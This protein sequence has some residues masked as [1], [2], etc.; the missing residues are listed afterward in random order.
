MTEAFRSLVVT[1]LP[2]LWRVHPSA[3]HVQ[4]RDRL[5]A[6]AKCQVGCEPDQGCR[7]QIAA[8][9]TTCGC[10][11]RSGRR[12]CYGLDVRES[13]R[14]LRR[15]RRERTGAALTTD[16]VT[17]TGARPFRPAL[18]PVVSVSQAHSG[19]RSLPPLCALRP[20]L[21]ANPN[22]A[23]P[24]SPRVAGSGTGSTRGTSVQSAVW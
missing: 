20:D 1:T 6:N 7:P 18:R 11:P 12:K 3:A 8:R 21:S 22:K 15:A 2:R 13:L 14:S 5:R 23:A 19:E 9:Q 24:S 17:R 4:G 16:D 10:R